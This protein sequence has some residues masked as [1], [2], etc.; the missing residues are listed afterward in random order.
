MK[1][2]KYKIKKPSIETLKKSEGKVSTEKMFMRDTRLAIMFTKYMLK[3]MRYLKKYT[4]NPEE[5]EK[6]E[7]NIRDTLKDLKETDKSF[8]ELQS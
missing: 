1:V 4:E 8:R 3:N 2:K 7:R 6:I 5:Y